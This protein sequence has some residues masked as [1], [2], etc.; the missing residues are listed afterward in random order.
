MNGSAR[1]GGRRG[2][3]GPQGWV[4]LAGLGVFVA[5]SAAFGGLAD[6]HADV[7]TVASGVAVRNELL[8]ATVVRAAVV[9]ELPDQYLSSGDGERL[10]V[11]RFQLVDRWQE[12]IGMPSGDDLT[13]GSNVFAGSTPMLRPAGIKATLATTAWADGDN[14]TTVLQPDV[15]ALVDAIWRIPDDALGAGDELTIG[16]RDGRVTGGQSILSSYYR[17]VDV[18]DPVAELRVTVVDDGTGQ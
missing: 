15:P 7:P 11:V 5:G 9:D 17:Y 12:P 2:I 1:V 6:V 4:T 3:G 18:G 14:S 10:L 8:Q 16:F 13:G